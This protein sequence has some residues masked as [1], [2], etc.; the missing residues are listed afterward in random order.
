VEAGYSKQAQAERVYRIFESA[1]NKGAAR[2]ALSKSNTLR[3]EE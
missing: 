3:A 1:C 2:L